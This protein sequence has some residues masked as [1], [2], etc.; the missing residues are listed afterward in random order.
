L[1]ASTATIAW[2]FTYKGAPIVAIAI[3]LMA[4]FG[5]RRL[6]VARWHDH[7]QRSNGLLAVGA[8]AALATDTANQAT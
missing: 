4:L 5:L 6:L 8:G 2:S 1:T 7:K 3:P